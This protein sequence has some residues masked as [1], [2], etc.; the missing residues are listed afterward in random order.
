ALDGYTSLKSLHL[1]G[2]TFFGCK[3]P[4]PMLEEFFIDYHIIQGVTDHGFIE[5]LKH[6]TAKDTLKLLRAT[7]T[8]DDGF[9]MTIDWPITMQNLT[10]L[11]LANCHFTEP[12]ILP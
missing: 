4:L 7:T 3:H 5:C 8:A 2:V 1:R 11:E 9:C 10:M 6:F 12:I